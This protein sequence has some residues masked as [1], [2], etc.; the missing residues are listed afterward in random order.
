M[1]VTEAIKQL[2]ELAEHGQST[3]DLKYRDDYRDELVDVDEF[4]VE[5]TAVVA[6]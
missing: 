4:V 2:K 3:A 5:E 6:Q 1:T